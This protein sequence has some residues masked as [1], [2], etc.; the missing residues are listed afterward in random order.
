MQID[1]G[2]RGERRHVGPPWVEGAVA[3]EGFCAV[4]DDDRQVG[5]PVGHDEEAREVA[6][7]HQGVEDE[8]VFPDERSKAGARSGRTSQSS[9]ANVL[10]H[11]TQADEEAVGGEPRDDCGRLADRRIPPSR[12]PPR[13]EEKTGPI[14]SKKLRLGEGLRR[15]DE[16]GAPDP[17]AR[18]DRLE[19]RRP[20]IPVERRHFG[21][22]PE[23][24]A[25]VDAPEVLMGVDQHESLIGRQA[26]FEGAR[27][28]AARSPPST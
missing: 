8:A 1:V 3:D 15:L 7:V 18:D 10:H 16:D 6:R 25:A 2:P 9:S 23:I 17:V 4:V 24:I 26:A 27:H 19:I 20:E 12:P 22:H 13:R 11:G 21:L 14:S 5:M 28:M